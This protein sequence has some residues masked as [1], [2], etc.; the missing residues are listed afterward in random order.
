[1]CRY[2]KSQGQNELGVLP[3]AGLNVWGKIVYGHNDTPFISVE[4]DGNLIALIEEIKYCP[5]CGKEF[6]RNV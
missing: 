6:K 5:Y 4:K 3:V 1:M 2:C